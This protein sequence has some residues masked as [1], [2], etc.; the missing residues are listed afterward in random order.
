MKQK[1]QTQWGVRQFHPSGVRSWDF[2]NNVGEKGK[3]WNLKLPKVRV[4]LYNFFLTESVETM[5]GYVVYVRLFK[6]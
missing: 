2:K 6:S 1:E 4:M 5:G 3:R